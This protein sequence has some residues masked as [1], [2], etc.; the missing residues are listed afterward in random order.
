MRVRAAAVLAAAALCGCGSPSEPTRITLTAET[1]TG[2]VLEDSSSSHPFTVGQRG[3]VRITLVSTAPVANVTMGLGVS[4]A[5]NGL[6]SPDLF[7]FSDAAR[8]GSTLTGPATPGAYC[9]HVY[10]VG[11]VAGAMTYTLLVEHP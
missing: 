9:A 8:A 6:C 10:D 5:G 7:G 3:P 4:V 2:T 1:F 11:N